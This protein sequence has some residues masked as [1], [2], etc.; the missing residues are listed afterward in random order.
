MN[1][2]SLKDSFPFPEIRPSQEKA[3]EKLSLDFEKGKRFSIFEL[4][5]GTGKSGLALSVIR[6]ATLDPERKPFV[7]GGTILTSQKILQQQYQ[8]E[9]DT[10]GL[11]DLR[12]S[13]NYTCTEHDD[14][15]CDIGQQMNKITGN[16]CTVCP[17]RQAKSNF[18]ASPIGVTNFSYFLT[19]SA[20]KEDS[21][22]LPAKKI[23]VIDEAHNT[24]N[25]LISHSEINISR[26][27][28]EELE[29]KLPQRVLQFTDIEGAKTW[30]TSNLI[31]AM[32]SF[33][34]KLRAEMLDP[35]KSRQ[36]LLPV[37][38]KLTNYEQFSENLDK[39]LE[40]SS[41]MWF[42]NQTENGINIKPLRGDVFAEEILFSR[43]EHIVMMSATI[44]D[45]KTFV[46]NLGIPT[47]SCGYL[48]LPSEFP[49]SNRPIIFA[50]AG[51]MSFKNYDATLPKLLKRIHRVLSKHE[52][53]KGIIH[54]NSFKLA[55]HIKE[56]FKGTPFESRLL[57][58]D[59][60]NRQFVV[61][62]HMS[63]PLPT[64]LL[65]P[66][67]TEGLDLRD[68]LS[69]F[70]VIAKIPF[71]SLADPYIK[72]RMELDPQWYQWQTCLALVQGLGRSIRSKDDFA[73]S[74]ILDGDFKMLLHNSASILPEWWLES[75]EFR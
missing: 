69:R 65:S 40:S 12:G 38:K 52:G 27:R 8:R 50:P 70:Q 54:C 41:K 19:D 33:T 43:A 15:T 56:Y 25:A 48:S 30:T 10:L 58:H 47:K 3:L 24:E 32:N 71:P 51:S 16:I 36:E 75:I 74:Y 35:G 11:A 45:P 9:F 53:E 22:K 6:A 66:S 31:P 42:I 20:Y 57:D 21:K 55:Q 18:C 64:V 4:P 29:V 61:E 60:K 5:T 73:V 34:G 26:Q 14:S 44:L 37:A 67:M 72:T 68:D 28:T 63:S 17:Y 13:S 39:F 49:A 1:F 59:S 7:S 62:Q 46:R 23:L 2:N